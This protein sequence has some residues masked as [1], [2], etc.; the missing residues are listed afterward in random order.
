M[1]KHR[2]LLSG[3]EGFVGKTVMRL[4]SEAPRFDQVQVIPL[5]GPQGGELD[6][7]DAAAV[8]A[9][10]SKCRPTA[11]IHLAAVAS[12]RQAGQSPR[13]AWDVNLI[14]TYNIASAIM[15]HAPE[16]RLVFAGSADAYGSSFGRGSE[17]VDED[18]PLAPISVYGA[19]KAAADIMLGQMAE[20]G[21]Q[22]I[23]FRPFNHTGPGQ[24]PYYAA[25]A[26]ALQLVRIERG[27]QAPE[28]EVGNLEA[29][30]DFLDVRDIACAYL[31]TALARPGHPG[32]FNLATGHPLAIGDMLELL[33]GHSVA[34]PRLRTEPSLLRTQDLEV[35]SGDPRRAREILGWSASIPIE[36]TLQD[37]LAH[38]RCVADASPETLRLSPA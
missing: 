9:A 31:E 25:S 34:R 32:A 36:K 3:A 14:G 18:M 22:A 16:A 37:L 11:V 15:E 23:R 38:W 28:I 13:L 19:T 2:V 8:A 26:F 27:W 35:M 21:L 20:A 12:P 7:R 17:P 1:G 24:S 10:V 4:A 33:L 29:R 5:C 6:I 30:R